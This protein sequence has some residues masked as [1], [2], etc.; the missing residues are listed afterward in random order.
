[1][2]FKQATPWAFPQLE[3][4][5]TAKTPSMP[6]NT[7]TEQAAAIKTNGLETAWISWWIIWSL[8]EEV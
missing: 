6:D 7:K 1:M 8:L 5:K 4:E 2:G 3:I